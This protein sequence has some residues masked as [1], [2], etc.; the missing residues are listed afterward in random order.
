MET[1]DLRRWNF[2]KEMK[3]LAVSCIGL[4][5]DTAKRKA[6]ILFR[7]YEPI[8]EHSSNEVGYFERRYNEE[9]KKFNTLKSGLIHYIDGE[10]K[11][12]ILL[13][14]IVRI[15]LRKKDV[16]IITKTGH[17]VVLSND[18]NYLRELL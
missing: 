7:K 1:K 18:F 14:Q 16:L 2:E 15:E 10:N 13:K 17:E 12:S 11:G 6:A 9:C 3:A 8:I 4:K 5:P